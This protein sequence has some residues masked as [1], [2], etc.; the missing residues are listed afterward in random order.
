[1]KRRLLKRISI[2][3]LS[4]C[5]ILC[6]LVAIGHSGGTDSRGGHYNRGTGEYHYH[7]GYSAHQHPGGVC[8]YATQKPTKKPT[9]TPKPTRKATPSP[10][11]KPTYSHIPYEVS[12]S[13]AFV[14]GEPY[15][16]SE[17]LET[18][19]EG[20]ELFVKA[21][22]VKNGIKWYKVETPSGTIGYTP[23]HYVEKK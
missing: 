21:Y 20:D 1:M 10:T 23:A 13:K 16:Q 17:P 12:V 11:P 14:H 5:I 4:L 15:F 22:L 2:I 19:Y 6:P 9:A 7:H 18:L 8:P 3:S